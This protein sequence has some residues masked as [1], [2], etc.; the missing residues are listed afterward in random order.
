ML[1]RLGVVTALSLLGLL[2]LAP[3][4]WAHVEIDPSDAVAGA[5]ET[6]TFSVAYEGAATTG[7]EIR[8][9]DGASVA[10]VPDKAGWTSTV[11]AAANTV[12]WSGGSSAAD[13]AFSV[14]VE[15]PTT[16]G[17]VLFPAIQ[18]TTDGEVAWIGEEET[19]GEE[20]NPAPRLTLTA[21]PNA[22]ST[23]TTEAT[24]S[25]TAATT[26][27]N[28]LPG[29]TLEAEER[30]DGSTS[31]APWI[32]GSGIA[33]LLAIGIGGWLLKRHADRE[34]AEASEADGT[35]DG[36][37]GDGTAVGPTPD[38]PTSNGSSGDGAGGDGRGGDR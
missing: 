18:Q 14:V 22:T 25:T 33:A 9:P 36:G 12:S 8:L 37:D 11:D 2:V 13:E 10:E 7:L 24:T 1:R 4:A 26:T 20:G 34:A 5:T 3:A 6:L 16:P 23:T 27:T 17:E 19:E 15:L 38:D 29:T 30:D 32:I 21:D 28:D 35:A 31:A